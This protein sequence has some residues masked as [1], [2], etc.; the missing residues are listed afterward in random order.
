MKDFLATLGRNFGSP[1]VI[2]ILVLAT[3]LLVLGESRD[4]FFVSVVITI[5]TLFAVVQ[6]VRAQRALK[7]LEL[8]SAPHA[9]RQAPSGE[10]SGAEHA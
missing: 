4:A 6:E 2:A 9:R 10:T 1:I 7:K 5:N 3:T 8:M